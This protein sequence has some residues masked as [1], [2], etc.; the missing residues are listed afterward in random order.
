MNFRE[1]ASNTGLCPPVWYVTHAWM[2]VSVRVSKLTFVNKLDR[3]S[4]TRNPH[5]NLLRFGCVCG[6]ISG[7]FRSVKA[8][9]P[10]HAGCERVEHSGVRNLCR[11]FC[12]SRL[13]SVPLYCLAK[14]DVGSHC[15]FVSQALDSDPGAVVPNAEAFCMR[16][17]SRLGQGKALEA[18]DDCYRALSLVSVEV[19]PRRQ[20][21]HHDPLSI[22]QKAEYRDDG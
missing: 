2:K 5:C 11:C 1:F 7:I 20:A 8:S 14:R 13:D 19:S 17:S 3:C 9:V 15:W 16:G 18:L 6:M 12:G 21:P 22:D 4:L 10:V